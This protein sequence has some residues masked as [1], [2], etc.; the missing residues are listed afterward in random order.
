M[1]L[2]QAEKTELVEWAILHEPWRESARGVLTDGWDMRDII[3][4]HA[5][6]LVGQVCRGSVT[7]KQL[8]AGVKWA[9]ALDEE[10]VKHQDVELINGKYVFEFTARRIMHHA[11]RMAL[12]QV[13]SQSKRT[14][15]TVTRGKSS[16]I[17]TK[18]R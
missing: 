2:E 3:E 6:E 12:E 17:G 13:K 16:T 8:R 10:V 9:N 4:L 15:L 11:G 5:D 18:A 1:E 7:I 14:V